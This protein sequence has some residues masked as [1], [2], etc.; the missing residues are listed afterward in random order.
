[1]KSDEYMKDTVD[2]VLNITDLDYLKILELKT[3]VND[4]E[5]DYFMMDIL[6]AAHRAIL[7]NNVTS[8]EEYHSDKAVLPANAAKQRI[9]NLIKLYPERFNIKHKDDYGAVMINVLVL[10]GG[11]QGLYL[12]ADITSGDKTSR[13]MFP[14]QLPS[15]PEVEDPDG[16]VRVSVSCYGCSATSENIDGVANVL[17]L[18]GLEGSCFEIEF[19]PDKDCVFSKITI[20]DHE[21]T[22]LKDTSDNANISLAETNQGYKLTLTNVTEDTTVGFSCKYDISIKTFRI[23][24][25]FVGCRPNCEFPI[26][27]NEGQSAVVVAT[28]NSGYVLNLLMVDGIDYTS[29]CKQ[30]VTEFEHGKL[31]ETKDDDYSL[32]VSDGEVTIKFASVRDDHTVA[33]HYIVPSFMI[34]G[35][36][37]HV[38]MEPNPAEVLMSQNRVITITPE[39]GYRINS[40]E[41]DVPFFEEVSTG[42]STIIK[43]ENV[44]QDITYTV[45]TSAVDSPDEPIPDIPSYT[46]TGFGSHVTMDPNPA[47]AKENGDATITITPDE[48]YAIFS[49]DYETNNYS[50]AT[51]VNSDSA[52]ILNFTGITGDIDYT[53]TTKA[54]STEPPTDPDEPD[55]PEVITYTV[56]G[57]G[58]NVTLN[59]N[60]ISGLTEHSSATIK[61]TPDDGYEIDTVSCTAPY[62]LDKANGILTFDDIC[63]GITYVVTTKAASKDP[64]NPGEPEPEPPKPTDPTYTVTGT[65]EHVT[66]TPN[67]VT[68]VVK[69]GTVSIKFVADDG[70]EVTDVI[71]EHTDITFDDNMIVISNI[72]SDVAYTVSTTASTNPDKPEDPTTPVDPDKPN[73][74]SKTYYTVTTNIGAT[75]EDN[76][77]IIVTSPEL[78]ASGSLYT[79][80]VEKDAEM[81]MNLESGYMDGNKYLT[82]MSTVTITDTDSGDR[83]LVTDVNVGTSGE[84]TTILE[85]TDDVIGSIVTT[86]NEDTYTYVVT[87]TKVSQNLS[88]AFGTTNVDIGQGS[89]TT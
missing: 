5:V 83:I 8:F 73:D 68:N 54:V 75:A 79:F 18:K 84:K 15:N 14:P 69:G 70:Y 25:D 40:I 9:R 37:E 30:G 81:V 20:N 57:S 55:V 43:F 26:V 76:H 77:N 31:T 66:L 64:V 78:T 38:R 21:F 82:K 6:R 53:V 60:P 12:M 74:P 22:S 87:I 46:V 62:V 50:S 67:P 61:I 42:T 28:A 32:S 16:K 45:I 27:V 71:S 41:S 59:P 58:T 72:T 56:I 33:C 47:T 51:Y 17:E 2:D 48:G 3:A 49:I 35:S 65:G 85:T 89:I 34:I 4:A 13:W 19:F 63:E 88:I 7:D 86:T 29:I 44:T 52:V 36:G 39:D 80:K 10:S 1:M 11:P 23:G 24:G